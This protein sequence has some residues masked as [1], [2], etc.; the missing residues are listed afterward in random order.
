VR[1]DGR[2]AEALQL[3]VDESLAAV[4]TALI[5]ADGLRLAPAIADA[6]IQ[7]DGQLLVPLE[8]QAEPLEEARFVARHDHEQLCHGVAC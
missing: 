4:S 7:N 3:V 1:A 8:F 2:P 6:P 5:T